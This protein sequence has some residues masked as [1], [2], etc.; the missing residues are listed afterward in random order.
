MI[1]VFALPAMPSADPATGAGTPIA[2]ANDMRRCTM[3]LQLNHVHL[4]T[5]DPEK[6]AK[7][8]VDTLGAKIVGQAGSNGYRL[9]LHGLALNV[10]TFLNQSREQK[11]GMEHIAIDTDELDAVV[12]KLKA[13]GI[14]ILEETTIS[15]GR[16][17]CFFEGPDGVQLEFIEMKK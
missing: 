11:Y 7:F 16:R 4:K 17:V 3:A 6:T 2:T 10:T 15:G 13:Q 12:E 8:Y 1:N 5:H 14:N 9:D